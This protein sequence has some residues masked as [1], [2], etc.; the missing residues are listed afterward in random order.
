MKEEISNLKKENEDLKKELEDSNQ[1]REYFLNS[2]FSMQFSHDKELSF[3]TIEKIAKELAKNNFNIVQ[4]DI[5]YNHMNRKTKILF[6]I[7]LKE[8]LL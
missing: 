4:R 3:G 5:L 6:A 7:E 8:R 1:F 2:I